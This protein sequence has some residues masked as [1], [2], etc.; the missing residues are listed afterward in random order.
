MEFKLMRVLERINHD[1][2]L[3]QSVSKAYLRGIIDDCPNLEATADELFKLSRQVD[4]GV[5]LTQAEIKGWLANAASLP[6]LELQGEGYGDEV[7]Y[8][9]E[10]ANRGWFV[11]R[12]QILDATR[13]VIWSGKWLSAGYSESI[14]MDWFGAGD[15]LRDGD[16]YFIH[17]EVSAG[18]NILGPGFTY[19]I[20]WHGAERGEASFEA[21]NTTCDPILTRI[22]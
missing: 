18:K 4:L 12:L 20:G 11:C 3:A 2:K 16:L 19:R 9:N 14:D 6:A 15:K 21:T 13:E 22:K 5:D 7:I 8:L 1:D 10:L 17:V